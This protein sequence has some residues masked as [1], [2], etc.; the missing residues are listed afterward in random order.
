MIREHVGVD[1]FDFVLVNSNLGH[2][3][4]GGQSQVIFKPLDVTRHP[5]VR[6]IDADVVNVKLPSHHDPEKLARVIMRKVW[7]A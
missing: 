3:P 6:F 1:L 4:T 2:T 5:E 7:Q